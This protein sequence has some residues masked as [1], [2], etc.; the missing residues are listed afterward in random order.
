MDSVFYWYRLWLCID[1]DIREE[2]DRTWASTDALLHLAFGMAGLGL[3]YL[4]SGTVAATLTWLGSPWL[5]LGADQAR[6][7]IGGVA[8]IALSYLPYRISV[9]GHLVNGELYKSLFD[10]HRSTLKTA[11]TAASD[12][13]RQAWTDLWAQLQY[14]EKPATSDDR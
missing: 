10:L 3:I 8:L 6:Y 14:G 5:L 2:V 9:P 13:E 11:L 1:K 12:A 4:A 7:A